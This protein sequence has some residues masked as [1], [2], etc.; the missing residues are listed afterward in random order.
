MADPKILGIHHIKFPVRDLERSLAF[1]ER[2]FGAERIAAADHVHGN[3]TR[4]AMI[5]DVPDLGTYLELRLN[6]AQAQRQRMFDPVTIAVEDR[7]A[8]QAWSE[9]LDGLGIDHSPVLVALQAWLLVFRDPD[10]RVLRL[11]TLERHG[12][13]L[14]PDEGSPWLAEAG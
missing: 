9:R 8:L 3:G 5:L 2:V 10:E 13:E 7:Q 1:Y 14:L 4:Y 6:P 12:P 11:Y